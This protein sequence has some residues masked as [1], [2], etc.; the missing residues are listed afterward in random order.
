[1]ET[2][3]TGPV[4]GGWGVV[5]L[6][7]HSME[8]P[9]SRSDPKTRGKTCCFWLLK[10]YCTSSAAW[11]CVKTMQGVHRYISWP[12]TDKWKYES[13]GKTYSANLI[14]L[15]YLLLFEPKKDFYY[16]ESLYICYIRYTECS[17]Y[18]PFSSE[19]LWHKKRLLLERVRVPWSQKTFVLFSGTWGYDYKNVINRNLR[20][21]WCRKI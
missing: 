8:P 1:M 3:L 19:Y 11:S 12:Y 2:W 17:R 20:L 21:R 15:K 13:T 7:V 16:S 6:S 9:I 4:K 18:K 5:I 10:G 14:I